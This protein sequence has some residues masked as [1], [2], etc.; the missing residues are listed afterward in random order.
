MIY[1]DKP[2]IAKRAEIGKCE[3]TRKSLPMNQQN[4]SFR[5]FGIYRKGYL[6]P[7]KI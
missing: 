1:Q 7:G 3:R 2:T 5:N 6:P 4:F